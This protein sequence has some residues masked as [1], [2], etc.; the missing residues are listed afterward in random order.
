MMVL[1]AILPNV[2]S[3][4]IE[5]EIISGETFWSKMF[6]S[7]NVSWFFCQL[8]Q[9]LFSYEI[10]QISLFFVAQMQII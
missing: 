6:A 5:G 4:N 8:K 10:P 2:S 7:L 9:C 3:A 1:L